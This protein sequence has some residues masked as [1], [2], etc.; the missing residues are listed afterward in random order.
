L[1]SY[2]PTHLHAPA[3]PPVTYS[4][5]QPIPQQYEQHHPAHSHSRHRPPPSIVYA[6]GS[7]HNSDH[8]APPTI[9][10]APTKA[11]GM[12]Y[13]VS[14]PTGSGFP[15]YPRITPA[16]YPTVHSHLASIHEETRYGSRA[17]PSRANTPRAPSPISDV[18]SGGTYYV[19]PTP[20]QKVKV[21]VSHQ[22]SA[23]FSFLPRFI[24]L[25]YVVCLSGRTRAF[26]LHG[27]VNH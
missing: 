13:T 1:P 5:S 26:P 8:Y 22:Q 27:H 25:T 23:Y 2:V 4:H 17:P 3:P 19:I 21:L 10:Y 9:V 6:P 15:Q 24:L 16:P 18:D 20:G 14:A 12:T 7:H 11:P